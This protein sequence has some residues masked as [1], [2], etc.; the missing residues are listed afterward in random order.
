MFCLHMSKANSTIEVS[1]LACV[2]FSD[3]LSILACIGI[4]I[5]CD[6]SSPVVT[7]M[8]LLIGCIS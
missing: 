1:M 2:L 7:E 4:L 3:K 8:H 6:L 5:T